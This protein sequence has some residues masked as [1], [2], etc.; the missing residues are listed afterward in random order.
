MEEKK[1]D[2]LRQTA[3]VDKVKKSAYKSMETLCKNASKSFNIEKSVLRRCKDYVY[4][5]GRGWLKNFPLDLSP[6]EPFKDRVSPTFKKLLEIIDDLQQI[7]QIE[8]LK[9]YLE[10]LEI[11]G[12]KINIESNPAKVS[13]VKEC[14]AVINAMC[15][16]QAVICEKADIIKYEHAPKS[17]KLNL[18][19]K[20]NYKDVYGLYSQK[21]N[22]RNINN[23]TQKKLSKLKMFGNTLCELNSTKGVNLK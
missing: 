1:I 4:Y 15:D 19:P 17:E 12:V 7:G 18:A 16:C 22:G 8:F 5:H 9:P 11:Y 23:S 10:A 3:E 20:E 6:E 21:V 2:L 13:S 14:K